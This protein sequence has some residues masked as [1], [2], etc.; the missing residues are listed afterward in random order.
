M[1][2]IEYSLTV[3]EPLPTIP[4][5]AQCVIGFPRLYNVNSA[6]QVGQYFKQIGSIRNLEKNTAIRNIFRFG[7]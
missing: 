1:D 4:S 3:R 5:D 2:I 6:V 7:L